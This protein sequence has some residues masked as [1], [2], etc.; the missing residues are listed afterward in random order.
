M[1][2]VG[3]PS[4]VTT[5]T[6]GASGSRSGVGWL[7]SSRIRCTACGNWLLTT[8]ARKP[9]SVS[10]RRTSAGRD[11]S[12]TSCQM[13]A[14]LCCA[15]V[16]GVTYSASSSGRDVSAC[17]RALRSTFPLGVRGM[18]SSRVNEEGIMYSGSCSFRK[19]RSSLTVGLDEPAGTT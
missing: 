3:R 11:C 12:S 18:D 14:T 7:F 4:N 13:A 6:C 5:L 19:E 17:G 8:P 10:R 15:P 1:R 2:M 9:L 16:C